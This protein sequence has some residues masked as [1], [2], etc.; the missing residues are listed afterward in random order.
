VRAYQSVDPLTLG[1]LWAIPI[2]LRVLLVENLRRLAIRIIHSQTG[3]KMADEFVDNYEQII[4]Q[5]DK[6]ESP[7]PVPVLPTEPLIQSYA[8]Q[9]LQRS[10]DPHLGA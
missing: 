5:S 8:V 9:I 7:L 1:E 3:R 10:H 2:T 6:P 4:A